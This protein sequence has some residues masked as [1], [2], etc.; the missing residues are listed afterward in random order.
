MYGI[1]HKAHFFQALIAVEKEEGH[2]RSPS[3]RGQWR[4]EA[5]VTVRYQKVRDQRSL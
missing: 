5:S 2:A 4:Q 1:G 3:W